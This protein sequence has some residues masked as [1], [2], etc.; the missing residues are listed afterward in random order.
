VRALALGLAVA[1]TV[2]P[3]P[4]AVVDVG[5]GPCGAAAA[6]GR[7]WVSNDAAGTVVAVDPRRNRV[8][9]TVTVGATACAIRTALGSLWV[10]QYG[11]DSVLRVDP[12]T[13]A[14][15]RIGVGDAP[16]DIAVTPD[17]VWVSNF[18]DGTLTRID[19][20]TNAV[21]ETVAAGTKPGSLLHRGRSLWIG[22]GS[23]SHALLRLDLATR[24]LDRIHVGRPAPQPIAAVGDAIWANTADDHVLRLRGTN[25]RVTASLRVRGVPAHAA[26]G[27]DGRL[28]VA[29]KKSNTVTR[30]DTASALVVDVTPAGRGA[31][32]V[33]RA[34]GAVWVTSYAGADLWR[35]R[36]AA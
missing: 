1:A 10:V 19:P 35:W 21:V 2:H 28:W 4:A 36:S 16:V 23:P 20:H 27:P 13:G 29:A 12:R 15:V 32:D 24:R 22:Q 11:T 5:N 25:G 30:I 17:G 18:G 3:R 33:L 14:I 9:R 6:A 31:Y 26:V 8:V 7:V 34:F